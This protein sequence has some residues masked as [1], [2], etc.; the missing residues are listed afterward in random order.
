MDS[1]TALK[2]NTTLRFNDGYTYTITGE[3]A[4]GG[5]GIVYNGF[6]MDN[7]SGKKV[8]R[9]KECYPFKCNL[10]RA[11]GGDLLVPESEQALFSEAKQ[12]MRRA[13]QLGSAF[14]L[15]DGLTNLTANTYNIFE[16]NNTLYVI[17]AYAQGQELSYERYSSVKDSI[18]AV[19]SV[20]A[21]IGRIH[22][23]G[24]LYLDIK[25]DNIMTLEGT[26]E[27][28]QL[29]DFDTVVPIADV[30]KLGDRISYTRGFA[31]LELQGG[32]Y[33][34]IGRHTDVYGIGA[35]LFYM[36]FG[37][38]PDAF[39]CEAD[40]EYD[41]SKSRL[42][43]GSY[44]DALVFRLTDFFHHTLANY[45]L[46][47][48]SNMETVTE[49]LSEL[50]ALAD[51]SAR[52]IISSKF[53]APAFFLGR[54]KETVWILQR[55]RGNAGGCSFLVG[56]GGIGKSTLMRYCLK[57]WASKLDSVLY[58][59]FSGTIEQTI[60]DDYAVQ[61]NGV[62]RDRAETDQ[63]YFDRKLGIL[64]E[65]G[66][67]KNNILVIDNYTG[68]TSGA[69]SRLLQLGWRIFFLSRDPSLAQW[70][71]TLRVGPISRTKVLLQ[72]FSKH[73]GRELR[74]EERRSAVSIIQNING[75]TL[76]LE[77]IAKQIGSPLCSL[78]LGQAARI[79]A[80]SGFSGIGSDKIGY[81]RDNVLYQKTI[82]QIVSSLFEAEGLS[83]S[84]CSLMK[85][86][87][88]FGRTGISMDRLCTML[89]LANR[90]DIS[91]LYHQGWI[92]V[93]DMIL[94]M[95]PVIEEAV[96][97]WELSQ[98]A[99][100]AAIKVFRYLNSKLRAEAHIREGSRYVSR[101][102]MDHE[103]LRE[104]LRLASAVLESGKREKKIRSL[105]I[106]RELLYYT[107]QNMPCENERFIQEKSEEFIAL[108]GQDSEEMLLKTSEI[109]LEF[110][111]EHGRFDEA[112]S[113]IQQLRDSISGSRRPEIRGRFYYILAGFY[114]AVLDGAYYAQTKEEARLVRWL[115]QST[116]KAIRWLRISDSD[117]F[118]LFLGECYR[119][120]AVVLIRSGI[121]R[122]R[123]VYGI[124]EKIQKRIDKYAQP[125]SELVRDYD[126]AM[127]WYY[128]YLEEDYRRASA[129]MFKAYDINERISTSEL[130][131]ID[132]QLCP[133]ANIMLEWEQYDQAAQY[134]LRCI[135]ICEEHLEIAAYA[136]RKVE[137]LGHLLEVY[138]HAEQ[139]G[140]CQAVIDK[141]EEKV[142]QS[143]S[144]L[145]IEDYVPEKVREV[146]RE[147][148]WKAVESHMED[149]QDTQDKGL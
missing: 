95:H 144:T 48:F 113:R 115:L 145:N 74:E 71:D 21:A 7:L 120:K 129:Y 19:K 86:L 110:L 31:A 26:R 82:R 96:S 43:G 118:G 25:P 143:G 15:T 47:R 89:E 103:E 149:N 23:E 38:V 75:H 50:Q 40:A 91:A 5:S 51:L 125:N 116:D 97:N 10:E 11:P 58:L 32:D 54:E 36:L 92:Y 139:Y 28:V 67:N 105:D 1:R 22:N 117:D 64:R 16:G 124:L 109:L 132:E 59:D 8:V 72:L 68:D 135:S 35:L 56:M 63:A 108:C 66:R 42:F 81:Q 20:A 2:S 83:Q 127:A 126:M 9:I 104:A 39:D 13:Y 70:Y 112:T 65:L 46:D 49:R 62:R 57:K 121:G 114:D 93:E 146:V 12:K 134:L 30:A 102:V 106:Y 140:K 101:R 73:I 111:Y 148:I 52:Y 78:S 34:R 3:L 24:F 80:D 84:Q 130:A 55:L 37:R 142:R 6:Y 14:F 77:L 119:L 45:Y 69:F 98:T 147:A 107:I 79:V 76:V 99:L 138:L 94:I 17:S 53:H 60:C 41:F 88:L 18:G 33:K 122:K 137:L 44:Q 100:H 123:Q 141:I 61:I 128:T 4:R 133:M 136:R 87:S 85:L 29:F 27:L 90:E 131:K